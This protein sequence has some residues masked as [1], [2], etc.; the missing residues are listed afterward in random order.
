MATEQSGNRAWS[1]IGTGAIK[2]GTMLKMTTV[3]GECDVATAVTDVP[4][5]I[6]LEDVAADANR[7]TLKGT[8]VGVGQLEGEIYKVIGSTTIAIL[9]AL[10]PTTGGKAVTI[11]LST[12]Y[13]QEWIWGIA[14]TAAGS[15]GT[16]MVEMRYG[17]QIA[18]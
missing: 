13:A 3:A 18:S 17:P 12:T 5:G 1:F 9:A 11:T 8:G 15:G 14:L 2:K 4:A 10:G 6:A 7:A 16:D